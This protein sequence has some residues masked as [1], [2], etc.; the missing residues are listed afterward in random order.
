MKNLIPS[1]LNKCLFPW[2][3]IRAAVLRKNSF[4]LFAIPCPQDKRIPLAC[5]YPSQFPCGQQEGICIF[6]ADFVSAQSKYVICLDELSPP[7]CMFLS[8]DGRRRLSQGASTLTLELDHALPKAEGRKEALL[9]WLV[10]KFL[11]S[12]KSRD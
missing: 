8:A 7:K 3:L 10:G 12:S 6:G 5:N 1:I 2:E 4:F 9:T 11:F